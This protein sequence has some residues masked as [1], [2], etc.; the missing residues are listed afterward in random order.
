MHG[1]LLQDKGTPRSIPACPRA[2][3]NSEWHKAPLYQWNCSC[4]PGCT[5]RTILAKTKSRTLLISVTL[6]GA[7][8]SLWLLSSL[9]HRPRLFQWQ[10][11]LITLQYLRMELNRSLIERAVA[12][13]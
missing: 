8:G 6:C 7:L 13:K 2:G 5:G 10:T 9:E 11:Q 3:D 1:L 12:F 4:P